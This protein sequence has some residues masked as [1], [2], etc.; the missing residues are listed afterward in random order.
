[1]E[2][3]PEFVQWATARQGRLVRSA[4]LMTGDLQAA[5]DLVQEALVKV[6]LRWERLRDGH[7][8]AY[9]R[10][11]IHHDHVSWWRRRREYAVPEP[12]DAA[13]P[14]SAST[15]DAEVVRAALVRLPPRQRSVLV[16]RFFEDLS[17]DQTAEV[18]GISPGTVK[19]QTHDALRNLRAHAPELGELVGEEAAHE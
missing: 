13:M 15:E 11:I 3:S 17:V 18:L 16:L 2:E 12:V 19:S 10:R 4:Y 9:A 14:Q 7:P 6:C 1:M 8:D 5:E